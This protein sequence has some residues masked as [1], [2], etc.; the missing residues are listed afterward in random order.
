MEVKVISKMNVLKK[1]QLGVGLIFV[2]MTLGI[3]L[4]FADQ[5]GVGAG[6]IILSYIITFSL[7]IKLLLAKKL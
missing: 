2:F 3:L 5:W 4:I 7:M 6:L 1:L